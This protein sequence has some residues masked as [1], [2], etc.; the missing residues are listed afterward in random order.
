M[1]SC[2]LN[3]GKLLIAKYILFKRTG[4][5]INCGIYKNSGGTYFDEKITKQLKI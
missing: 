5:G 4:S 1:I 2:L 3:M